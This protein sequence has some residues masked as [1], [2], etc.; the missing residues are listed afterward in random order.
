[1]AEDNNN[2]KQHG[3]TW[4]HIKLIALS[5][6]AFYSA[7]VFIVMLVL[8]TDKPFTTDPPNS[9]CDALFSQALALSKGDDPNSIYGYRYVAGHSG[10]MICTDINETFYQEKFA[11]AKGTAYFPWEYQATS[12]DF[13]CTG[14]NYTEWTEDNRMSNAT[15]VYDKTGVVLVSPQPGDVPYL[16]DPVPNG[17]A[18]KYYLNFNASFQSPGC[19]V[20]GT[21]VALQL[22]DLPHCNKTAV[23]AFDYTSA[24]LVLYYQIILVL[25]FVPHLMYLYCCIRFWWYVGSDNEKALY[26]YEDADKGLGAFM[27]LVFMLFAR[28]AEKICGCCEGESKLDKLWDFIEEYV[29]ADHPLKTAKPPSIPMF[30]IDTFV[31]VAELSFLGISLYG[32]Q[33]IDI[34]TKSPLMLVTAQCLKSVVILLVTIVQYIRKK[35]AYNSAKE[36][37][38]ATLS[39]KMMNEKDLQQNNESV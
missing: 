1:M 37:G 10:L 36:N 21:G 2:K 17:G 15:P 5:L 12:L 18:W 23:W 25:I 3:S 22:N 4:H 39:Y 30:C 13:K 19:G 35:F 27:L 6:L 34:K 7:C 29:E 11:A 33:P 16:V 26:Y 14:L 38:G 9:R 28:C 31:S 8:Q 24:H 20:N 32:C